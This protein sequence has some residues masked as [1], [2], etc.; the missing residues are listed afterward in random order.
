MQ[1]FSMGIFSKPSIKF[2]LLLIGFL[3]SPVWVNAQSPILVRTYKVGIISKHSV[4]GVLVPKPNTPVLLKFE[5]FVGNTQAYNNISVINTDSNGYYETIIPCY[6]DA[7]GNSSGISGLAQAIGTNGG[8]A[9]VTGGYSCNQQTE[10]LF[11]EQR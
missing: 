9:T 6:T 10:F 3:C 8:T 11:S 7:F 4:N 2:F 5:V 1:N